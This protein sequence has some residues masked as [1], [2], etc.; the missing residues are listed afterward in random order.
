L[1]SNCPHHYKQ[2]NQLFCDDNK[3]QTT[4]HTMRKPNQDFYARL[5]KELAR[6]NRLISLAS[7]AVQPGKSFPLGLLPRGFAEMLRTEF[8]W[9][10]IHQ[11]CMASI[12]PWIQNFSSALAIQGAIVEEKNKCHIPHPYQSDPAL[13]IRR[14]PVRKRKRRR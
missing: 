9:G 14:Q 6:R 11:P 5:N 8:E 10:T 1:S 3:K 12:F 4:A 7:N 13:T 2:N